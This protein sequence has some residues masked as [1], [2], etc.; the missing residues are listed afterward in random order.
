PGRAP[1]PSTTL[2]RSTHG[3]A[4]RRVILL[5][6]PMRRASLRST[7]RSPPDSR[8][9]GADSSGVRASCAVLR[10]AVRGPYYS[11]GSNRA[12]ASEQRPASAGHPGAALLVV[13][14]SLQ[15]PQAHPG[16]PQLLEAARAAPH[17][18]GP[19]VDPCPGVHLAQV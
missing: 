2:F 14:P 9:G 13:H 3:T 8:R 11:P 16:L 1:C 6:A 19:G 18:V 12:G 17:V 5:P 7:V 4:R 15:L 10:R